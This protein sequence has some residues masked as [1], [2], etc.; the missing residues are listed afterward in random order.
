MSLYEPEFE[1]EDPK[2]AREFE[3]ENIVLK[4]VDI[5]LS[6]FDERIDK[7][8]TQYNQKLKDLEDLVEQNAPLFKTKRRTVFFGPIFWTIGS[9][10]AIVPPMILLIIWVYKHLM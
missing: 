8:M 10:I 1:S 9:A 3:I 5:L 7:L 4:T 6:K 2:K